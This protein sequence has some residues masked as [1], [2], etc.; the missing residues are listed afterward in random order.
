MR[1]VA[2]FDH[3]TSAKMRECI[4]HATEYL[5]DAR[6]HASRLQD[7]WERQNAMEWL[8]HMTHLLS[9]PM[10]LDPQT[11]CTSNS[12]ICDLT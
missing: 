9:G 1:I 10:S 8:D 7:R 4:E 2:R 3:E 5:A 12:Q 11:L 6:Y